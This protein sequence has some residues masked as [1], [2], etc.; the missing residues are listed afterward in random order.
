MVRFLI[1]KPVAV[2]TIYL[3]FVLLGLV[4]VQQIPVSPLPN[5][6]IPEIIVHVNRHNVGTKELESTVVKPLKNSLLQVLDLENLHTVTNAGNAIIKLR[7][8][9]G[10]SLDYAF[11]EVNEKIDMAMANMPRD[12]DR[13]QVV[14]SSISDL[15]V[16]YLNISYKNQRDAQEDRHLIELSKL[17]KQIIKRRLEQ[18]KQVAIADL[19]GAE[20]A[21]VVIVPN[22]SALNA[23]QLTDN[24]F[25]DIILSRNLTMG[26]VKAKDGELEYYIRFSNTAPLSAEDIKG[27]N[28]VHKG[29]MFTIADVANVKVVKADNQGSFIANNKKA[30]NFAII[31][32]PEARMDDLRNEMSALLSRF[33][34]DYP[35]IRFEQTQ[36]QTELLEFSISNL[37]QDLYAGGCLGFVLMFFFLR[38]VRS[39]LLIGITIP[40]SLVI[41]ILFF[42]LF[43][44]SINIISLSGL[45]LGVGLMI[46]NSIIVIDNITQFKENGNPLDDACVK[47]TNEIIRPLLSSVL[48]TCSVFLPLIFLSGIAGALFYDQAMAITIGLAVSLIISITLLPVLYRIVHKNAKGTPENKFFNRFGFHFFERWYEAGFHWV[49]NHKRTSLGIVLGLMVS[50]VFF[51]K[52]LKKE[53]LPVF[54]QMELMMELDWNENVYLEESERRLNLLFDEIKEEVLLSE[55][56][57]GPQQYL[58]DRDQ[59]LQPSQAQIY[60]K[61]KDLKSFNNLQTKIISWLNSN[62]PNSTF[63]LNKPQN[64]FEQVFG[65]TEA[66]LVVKFKPVGAVNLFMPN[67]EVDDL[68]DSLKLN[69]PEDRISAL[70]K[71]EFISVSANLEKMMLYGVSLNDVHNSLVKDFGATEIGAIGDGEQAVPIKLQKPRADFYTAMQSLKVENEN[72][73]KIPLKELVSV[74]RTQEYQKVESDQEGEYIAIEMQTNYPEKVMDYVN[75]NIKDAWQHIRFGGS[76]FSNQKLVEELGLVLMVSVLLLYFILAAQFESLVQPLIVL[77]ELPISISG[78]LFM[79]Y[80]FDSSLNLISLI[81]LVVM[82]GI[83][84]NDS[85][86]KIDTINDL[87]R[88]HGYPLM[89]AIHTAGVRRLKSIIMTSMTTILA[90]LPF[91]WGTDMGSVLQRPLS[92]TLIGSMVI[93][94]PVSLYFIPLVYWFC[95]RSKSSSNNGNDEPVNATII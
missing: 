39:P 60:F 34:K 80:I 8:N 2:L 86:L 45:V 10:T 63:A 29:R 56:K 22:P 65:S 42:K 93:G 62:Y 55:M 73:A 37:R 31:K 12:L 28:F 94:T 66:P 58:V 78:A 84:I 33:R 38:N 48:T 41:S 79:L 81:G 13:P 20:E 70:Q 9:Y 72:H 85:I 74:S 76:F 6:D 26:N 35:Q 53:Q 71:Q 17:A 92:L 5:V 83:V 91:L 30:I 51:F 14:K 90:V 16:F 44:I 25:K 82:C 61:A 3:A 40:V 43:H 11:L 87:R 24:D 75:A 95:Y 89:K 7:F 19:S 88:Q 32:Q 57:I 27:I 47:G 68:V 18:T 52:T 36:D 59:T 69:F 4:A 77:L 67:K 54:Q 64:L 21:Q 50:S 15:P 1:H 49:F 23:L 46:D